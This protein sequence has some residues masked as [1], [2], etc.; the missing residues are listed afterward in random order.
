MTE[1]LLR[2]RGVSRSF[3]SAHGKPT[4]ALQALISATEPVD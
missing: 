4:V 1:A 3:P 2:V